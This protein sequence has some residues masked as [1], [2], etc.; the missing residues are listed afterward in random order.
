VLAFRREELKRFE[1]R[2]ARQ[3]P[4]RFVLEVDERAGAAAK[5]RREAWCGARG[6]LRK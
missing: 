4:P 3:P 6:G 2:L 1:L 5:R